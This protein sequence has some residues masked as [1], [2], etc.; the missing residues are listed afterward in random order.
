MFSLTV[1]YMGINPDTLI[2]TLCISF[3]HFIYLFSKMSWTIYFHEGGPTRPWPLNLTIRHLTR[4][5]C[6]TPSMITAPCS[7]SRHLHPTPPIL[8]PSPARLA[9]GARQDHGQGQPSLPP[10]A[11]PQSR[12]CLLECLQPTQVVGTKLPDSI[13]APWNP[14]FEPDVSPNCR[15]HGGCPAQPVGEHV[16]S[17]RLHQKGKDFPPS[18]VAPWAFVAFQ[19]EMSEVLCCVCRCIWFWL[20]SS[21]SLSQSSPCLRLCKC[22]CIEVSIVQQSVVSLITHGREEGGG[23]GG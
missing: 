22:P 16:C 13:C 19:C 9:T 20:R 10:G 12:L 8:A 7:H 2:L 23:S 3:D 15:R 17:P 11:P 14:M 18:L 6:T 1:L 21:R 5:H 4:M